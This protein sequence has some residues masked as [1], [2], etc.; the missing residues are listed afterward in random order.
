[1]PQP[2]KFSA[3]VTKIQP[4][5]DEVATLEFRCLSPR[6]RWKPGQFLHL[7]LDAYE[8]SGHWPESRC[9]TMASGSQQDLVRLTIAAKGPFTRRILAELRPGRKVW[10]KAPYGDFIVRT[11]PQHDVVL[12][13][14]GTGVTPFVAFM[15]DALSQ[16]LSGR[17]WLHYGARTQDLLVFRELAER[18]AGNFPPSARSAMPSRAPRGRDDRRP[19]RSGPGRRFGPRWRSRRLLSLRTA[20]HDC[21]LPL[22]LTGELGVPAEQVK[23][24]AW[25]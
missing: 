6:P 17:V 20:G 2:I 9:F 18:C 16:G 1:M 11:A 15:E 10:M 3:E 24:D 23:I 22:A 25:E 12:I 19:H 7:A 21:R 8:P 5:A 14:G 13:A 4:H